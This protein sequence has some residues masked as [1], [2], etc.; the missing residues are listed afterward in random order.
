MTAPRSKSRRLCRMS[1]FVTQEQFLARTKTVT[2][3][4]GWVNLRPGTYLVGVQK[5]QGLKKGEHARELGVIFVLTVSR[6]PIEDVTDEDVAREGF[7]DK[8]AAWFAS[9][10]CE[11]AGC[12]ADHVITRIAYRYVDRPELEREGL[13]DYLHL[14]RDP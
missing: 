10:F 2:R 13:L 4:M 8:D 11:M 7:P 3:R 9:M 6:E 12:E 1:F 14:G 5:G